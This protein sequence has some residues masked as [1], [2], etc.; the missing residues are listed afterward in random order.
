IKDNVGDEVN[1]GFVASNSS[2][3]DITTPLF[4]GANPSPLLFSTV[5]K[6]AAYARLVSVRDQGFT[7]EEDPP[8][9]LA[10]QTVLTQGFAQDAIVAKALRVALSQLSKIKAYMSL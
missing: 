9:S 5:L 3:L 1:P 6:V 7:S 8:D 10:V 2:L 4:A